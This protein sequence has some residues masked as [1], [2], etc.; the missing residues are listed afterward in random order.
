MINKILFITI[1][2]VLLAY[3]YN[4]GVKVG[5]ESVKCEFTC[6]YVQKQAS[7]IAYIA[8]SYQSMYFSCTKGE[9]LPESQNLKDKIDELVAK[10]NLDKGVPSD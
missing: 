7:D 8:H 1:S 10:Y 3:T 2:L 5:K 9:I 4:F 6:S